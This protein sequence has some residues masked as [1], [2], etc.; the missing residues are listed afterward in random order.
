M[1]YQIAHALHVP[2]DVFVVRK[3]GVPGHEELALGAIAASGKTVFNDSIVNDLNLSKETIQQVIA[4]EKI[5]LARREENYRGTR[6]FP[7]LKNK[8][9]IIVDDGIA[10]GATMR[11]A[12]IALRQYKP[13]YIIIA[14]PVAAVDNCEEMTLL[15]DKLICPLQPKEFYAVGAWYEEFDQTTD[16]EV[17]QLLTKAAV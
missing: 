13:A 6:P 14:V 7:E 10:T 17:R 3:L 9:V 16:A 12:V 5:E 15:V 11:T 2:L 8:T 1:A 4:K